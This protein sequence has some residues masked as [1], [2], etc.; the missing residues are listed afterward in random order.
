MQPYFKRVSSCINDNICRCF[1]SPLT[2]IVSCRSPQILIVFLNLLYVNT[3]STRN[4]LGRILMQV[5]LSS[6]TDKPAII[7]FS[8]AEEK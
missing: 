1:H 8:R 5:V 6:L 7:K 3:V 2:Y 4:D